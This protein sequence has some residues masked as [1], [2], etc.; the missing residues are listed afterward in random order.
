[1]CVGVGGSE[2]VLVCRADA[3]SHSPSPP[4]PLLPPR[5]LIA[6]ATLPSL[7]PR[8]PPHP[9]QVNDGAGLVIDGFPR[10]ALQVDFV[11]LLH[12]K[13]LALSL[14]H[15]DT[16]EEWRFP[17]PS[18]KVGVCREAWWWCVGGAWG[19]MGGVWGVGRG[20]GL[21]WQAPGLWE[22]PQPAGAWAPHPPATLPPPTAP[23]PARAGRHPVRGRGGERAA[24]DAP[25]PARLAT[26]QA[27]DGRRHR[28][29]LGRALHRCQRGAVP[30]ALPSV[31]GEEG[32]LPL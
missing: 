18:F 29:R 31:Q 1:M 4:C 21:S 20:R 12:D 10:T 19:R 32:R 14:G 2:Y 17:R 11:K 25:R 3:G 30:P 22:R 9:A 16:P 27:C 26:Q 28:R 5:P 24:P 7:P 15:A 23:P 13:L 8:P 6:T